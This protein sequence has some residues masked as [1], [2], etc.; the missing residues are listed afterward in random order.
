MLINSFCKLHL[1]APLHTSLH[2]EL[3]TPNG[4]LRYFAGPPPEGELEANGRKCV[5]APVCN[6]DREFIEGESRRIS[7]ENDD[8]ECQWEGCAVD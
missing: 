2:E 1:D 7:V 8:A 5:R 3:N 4:V 6:P